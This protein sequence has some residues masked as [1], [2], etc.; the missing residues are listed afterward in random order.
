MKT[1]NTI[2]VGEY[3]KPISYEDAKDLERRFFNSIYQ[4]HKDIYD[5]VDKIKEEAIYQD[6][7]IEKLNNSLNNIE[8]DLENTND[9]N[10][11]SLLKNKL[12]SLNLLIEEKTKPKTLT[13]SAVTHNKIKYFCDKKGY[14]I[15]D[16]VTE[17]L[18]NHIN[19]ELL[20]EREEEAK[21]ERKK[22]EKRLLEKYEKNKYIIE[23][24]KSDKILIN[25]TLFRFKGYTNDDWA[26]YD[27]L[28]E[29]FEEDTKDFTCRL[30]KGI[31]KGELNTN[32]SKKNFKELEIEEN[33][34]TYVKNTGKRKEKELEE[35]KQK[36]R[37]NI[38]A[39]IKKIGA[40]EKDAISPKKLSELLTNFNNRYNN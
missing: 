25:D 10:A 17:A 8:K 14:K 4:N 39:E 5:I 37:E 11:I 30:V 12:D 24:F 27:Y 1:E 23:P 2:S 7:N 28:G 3:E 32:Y 26:V 35:E 36:A 18:L 33:S 29:N 19:L 13:I 16:F 21:K 34:F 6:E 40:G 22:E 31:E 15:S 38:D 20:K 9:E